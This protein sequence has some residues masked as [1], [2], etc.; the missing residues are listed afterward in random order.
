[1]CSLDTSIP[2]YV[3]IGHL[4]PTNAISHNK[5]KQFSS[6]C[7]TPFSEGTASVRSGSLGWELYAMAWSLPSTPFPTSNTATEGF[8]TRWVEVSFMTTS[9]TYYVF[10]YK[11]HCYVENIFPKHTS[12]ITIQAV[13]N[14]LDSSTLLTTCASSP[15]SGMFLPAETEFTTLMQTFLQNDPKSP[16]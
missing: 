15:T 4:D 1:M 2:V 13:S 9:P 12:V 14:K 10:T 3:F 6:W 11:V 7:C 16:W 8:E 5:S